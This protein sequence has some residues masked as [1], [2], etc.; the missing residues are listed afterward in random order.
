MQTNSLIIL[1][2]YLLIFLKKVKK[3]KKLL[4]RGKGKKKEK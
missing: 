4:A 2:I 1:N 3:N